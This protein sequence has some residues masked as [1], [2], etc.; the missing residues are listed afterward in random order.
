[1]FESL[2]S[3]ATLERSLR[4]WH[5]KAAISVLGVE[6]SDECVRHANN[7]DARALAENI[8]THLVTHEE[9]MGKKFQATF[10]NI[11]PTDKAQH[12]ANGANLL[13]AFLRKKGWRIERNSEGY[14]KVR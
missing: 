5:I 14:C 11:V 13:R 2:K 6:H 1:M 12:N 8:A 3:V 10:G 4:D 7:M 9:C